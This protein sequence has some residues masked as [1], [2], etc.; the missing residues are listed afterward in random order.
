MA[1][2][3]GILSNINGLILRYLSTITYR[4]KLSKDS[5][6]TR[7]SSRGLHEFSGTRQPVSGWWTNQYFL[8]YRPISETK[9]A[10]VRNETAL[11]WLETNGRTERGPRQCKLAIGRE[12]DLQSLSC[13]PGGF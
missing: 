13:M 10:L 1:S 8:L 12:W 9:N 5:G 6:K 3:R 2:E 11:A 7:H 4:P